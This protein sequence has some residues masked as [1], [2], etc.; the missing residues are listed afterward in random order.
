M[1]YD[2]I[3]KGADVVRPNH[4]DTQRLDI[5]VRDGKVT[6]LAPDL[7]PANSQNVIDG[8]GRLAFPG[9]VDAH[10]HWGIYNP[11][12]EDAVSESRAAAQGGTTTAMTYFR[13]GQYYLNKGGP[14]RD[15]FPEVLDIAKGKS[16]VDY[17]FHL[18]PME[19][20]HIDEIPMLIEEFGVPS[21]KIFM[22]YGTHGLHGRSDDQSSFLMTPPDERYDYAHFEFIM[23]GAQKARERFPDIADQISVSLHC[24]TAE[25]MTAYTKMVEEDGSLSGLEAYSAARPP[26]SE[27]LAITIA[28]YLAHAAGFPNI[29]LLH[30]SSAKAIEAALLMRDT[31][32]HVNFRRE[33]TVGH[34]LADITTANGLYGKVNPPL[35]PREDVEALWDAVVAGDVDWVVSD[36]ACC[37]DE[38]KIG[39]DRDDVFQAK[40]GFGGTEYLLNGVYSE[41]T[42]RGLSPN[43]IAELVSW[44]PAQRFGLPSKGDLGVGFDADIV[45]LNPDAT[46]TIQ[47][48]ESESA[49]GY[50]VF[51]GFELAGQVEDVWVRGARVVEASA[52]VGS[53]TGQYVSRPQSE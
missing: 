20:Q 17:A 11:L 48:T 4:P 21:F 5:G 50:S 27:G 34:L 1:E 51:E 37:K 32:P 22:F 35:R 18:A 36:H 42:R 10:C 25:I 30:L 31:F 41:G 45:L 53:P 3:I 47:S 23:R 15:F 16:F 40:S 52:I 9:A 6:E 28:A 19:R 43:R 24:E 49:Q 13:T 39:E 29:N 2:L 33:V 8:T 14:Y 46:W 26:H 12:A 44:N 7:D 38:M